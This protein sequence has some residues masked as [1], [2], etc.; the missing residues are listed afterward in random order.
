ML[1]LVLNGNHNPSMK[2]V[3][4]WVER[5]G[6]IA[7]AFNGVWATELA[8]RSSLDPSWEGFCFTKRVGFGFFNDGDYVWLIVTDRQ[9]LDSA[10]FRAERKRMEFRLYDI[11]D[12]IYA[13]RLR[14]IRVISQSK[15][16]FP[17]PAPQTPLELA[18]APQPPLALVPM[19]HD[20]VVAR[21]W[22]FPYFELTTEK[23]LLIFIVAFM[24][25]SSC[26]Q[27]AYS[28]QTGAAIQGVKN[29]TVNNRRLIERVEDDVDDHRK[30]F[31]EYERKTKAE[32]EEQDRKI[33]KINQ[34]VN[35]QEEEKKNRPP[36]AIEG[37]Q[38][39][40]QGNDVGFA[41][42]KE[43]WSTYM[44]G[45]LVAVLYVLAIPLCGMAMGIALVAFLAIVWAFVRTFAEWVVQRAAAQ[46]A[47]RRRIQKLE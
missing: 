35:V 22:T 27:E 31:R 34:W 37:P 4:D 23:A 38:S 24:V 29:D 3:D 36:P 19:S 1:G 26:K 2:Q 17:A 5:K 41:Q 30:K 46:E 15:T 8:G 25:W 9:H 12:H 18:P 43:S 40:T 21:A 32:N 6:S 14:K 44:W 33:H 39:K 42:P 28:L 11:H 10:G 7:T 20:A 16:D 45:S 13:D 47:R